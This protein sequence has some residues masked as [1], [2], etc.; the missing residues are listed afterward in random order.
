MTPTPPD[1]PS[2]ED[3][4]MI[5]TALQARLA[6]IVRERLSSGL[7]QILALVGPALITNRVSPHRLIPLFDSVVNAFAQAERELGRD[8]L[9]HHTNQIAVHAEAEG[10]ALPPMTDPDPSVV[11][12]FAH[13][14]DIA[15]S[16]KFRPPG[17]PPSPPAPIVTP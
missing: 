13:I 12:L 11:Q 16:A 4:T 9:L 14:R 2:P 8:M 15:A 3:V 5:A 10:I 17:S 6:E 7:P 1:E